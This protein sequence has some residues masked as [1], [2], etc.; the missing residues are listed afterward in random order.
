MDENGLIPEALREHIARLKAAGKTIVPV[1]DPQLHNRL[2]T[3]LGEPR[4]PEIAR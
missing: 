1:H 3:E 2:N 4:D